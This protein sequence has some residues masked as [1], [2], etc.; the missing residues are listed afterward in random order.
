MSADFSVSQFFII[1]YSKNNLFYETF[2]IKRKVSEIWRYFSK[3]KKMKMK[4]E[5]KEKE[6]NKNKNKNNS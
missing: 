1:F 2:L 5:K 6:K 3:K 4:K